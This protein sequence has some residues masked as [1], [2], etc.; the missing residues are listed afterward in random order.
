MLLVLNCPGS[1]SH[2]IRKWKFS[3]CVHNKI[4]HAS[5]LGAAHIVAQKYTHTHKHTNK[6][7]NKQANK[8][9]N[10]QTNGRRRGVPEETQDSPRAPQAA[11]RAQTGPGSPKDSYSSTNLRKRR[12]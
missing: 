6:Q 5:R 10:K 11:Q 4:V 9:T 3:K 7:T 8:Q 12:C 1:K 2:T